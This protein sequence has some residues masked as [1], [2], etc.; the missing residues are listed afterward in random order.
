M[1]CLNEEQ[2]QQYID[3][4]FS[5]QQ[6]QQIKGHVSECDSCA[7]KVIHQKNIAIGIKQLLSRMPNSLN[8]VPEFQ[9]SERSV[10]NYR[11]G[12]KR[13]LYIVSAAAVII[14]VLLFTP[15]RSVKTDDEMLYLP[16][17]N[18]MYDANRSIMQQDLT[19]TIVD[20]EGNISQLDVNN[21]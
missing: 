15:N 13:T 8:E 16:I 10:K 6:I 7:E 3:G 11:P 4:E 9:Y 2:I 19:I 14:F 5:E 1:K 18:D 17:R 20:P 12:F 21:L